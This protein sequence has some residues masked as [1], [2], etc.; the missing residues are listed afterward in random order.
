A[1]TKIGN[2]NARTYRTLPGESRDRHES[3]HALR[4][5]IEPGSVAV[6]AFFAESRNAGVDQALVD[7]AHGGIVDAQPPFHSGAIILDHHV[8]VLRQTFQNRETFW[9][10]EV[11]GETALVAMQILEVRTMAL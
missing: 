6:G 10:L 4:D 2:R 5:L 11:E 3:A 1:G 9:C 7:R 8:G